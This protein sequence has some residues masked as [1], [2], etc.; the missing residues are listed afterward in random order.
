MK[1]LSLVL[2]AL[3]STFAQAADSFEWNLLYYREQY[4]QFCF[5]SGSD[6][7]SAVLANKNE[8]QGEGRKAVPIAKLANGEVI[9]L[10]K[11]SSALFAGEKPGEYY[12]ISNTSVHRRELGPFKKYRWKTV[13]DYKKEMLGLSNPRMAF[14]AKDQVVAWVGHR[15]TSNGMNYNYLIIWDLKNKKRVGGAISV[16]YNGMSGVQFDEEKKQIIVAG[17]NWCAGVTAYDYAGEEKRGFSGIGQKFKSDGLCLDL[18]N[19]WLWNIDFGRNRSTGEYLLNFSTAN[20]ESSPYP[21]RGSIYRLDLARDEIL[22]T[23]AEGT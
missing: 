2:L 11:C 9:P 14:N 16:G 12:A 23:V 1:S 3:S 17:V 21:K 22:G 8:M 20:D 7:P 4:G 13:V 15:G 5:Y 10:P 18:H 19:D 6:R